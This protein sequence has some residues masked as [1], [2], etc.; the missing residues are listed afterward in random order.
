[1]TFLDSDL[2]V[3]W[4]MG[5]VFVW[6][7]IEPSMAILCACLPTLNPV[8]QLVAR[9]IFGPAAARIFGS[10]FRTNSK[11]HQLSSIQNK[12]HS[13]QQLGDGVRMM[14]TKVQGRSEDELEL[15]AP[16]AQSESH[17]K[18]EGPFSIRVKQDFRWSEE[19]P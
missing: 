19:R 8:L 9:T 11:A 16:E 7:T 12:R 17:Y 1:M 18:Q 13:F 5:N 10:S 14:D 15:T 3:T 6:S 4:I 2:D